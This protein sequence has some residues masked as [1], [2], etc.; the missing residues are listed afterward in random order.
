MRDVELGYV[1][2]FE[3]GITI[4]CRFRALL[5]KCRVDLEQSILKETVYPS[6]SRKTYIKKISTKY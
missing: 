1:D 2:V 4:W 3:S 6:K 5:I